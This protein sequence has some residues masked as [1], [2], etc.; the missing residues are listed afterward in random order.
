[1]EMVPK[2]NLIRASLTSLVAIAFAKSPSQ[3]Y[4]LAVHVAQQASFYYEEK[5]GGQTIHSVVFDKSREEAARAVALLQYVG[6]WKSTQV[7]SGGKVLQD[8]YKISQI[9][10][11]YLEAAACDDWKAHC[12]TI[13]DDPFAEVRQSRTGISLVVSLGPFKMTQEIKID[14]YIFPCAY[15][16]SFFRRKSQ[17]HPSDQTDQ[18]QATAIIVGCDFCPYFDAKEYKKV[19]QRIKVLWPEN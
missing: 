19:G 6:G 12:F 5:V 15:L 4:R 10:R 13:I 18:I 7:F 1:M 2:V 17:K 14:E 3:S 8:R 9:L 11:C 16:S